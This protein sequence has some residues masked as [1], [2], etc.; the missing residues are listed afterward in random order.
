MGAKTGI[1]W[2][3][4]TWN[5][6]T[7]CEHV[8]PGCDNC[9]AEKI[10]ERFAG[11]KPY[12]NG[13]AP[14]VHRDRMDL[15]TRWRGKPR[16]VFVNSMSDLHHREFSWEDIAEVY[17]R[18][19]AE[20]EHDYLVLTKRPQRMAEFLVGPET[21]R[22]AYAAGV[23]AWAE[24]TDRPLDGWLGA[25][26]LRGLPDHI[27]IGTSIEDNQWAFRADW[28]RTIPAVVRAISA[29]PLIGPL[30]QLDLAG[31]HWVIVGGESGNRSNKFRPMPHEWARELLDR[32]RP[33]TSC[34]GT[35]WIEDECYQGP[36]ALTPREWNAIA[37]TYERSPGDGLIA[38]GCNIPVDETDVLPRRDPIAFFFKQSAGRTSGEH[39]F[40]DDERIE[41]YPLPHPADPARRGAHVGVY[42]MPEANA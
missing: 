24:F 18:M 21:A 1:S 38:C 16:R 36:D 4:A 3:E 12:P 28:L 42:T 11:T 23:P 17:D 22:A 20:P 35:R 32:C 39:P 13:F 34:G 37:A 40:L 27:W 5:P 15:P 7:G 25:R 8:S 31:I 30:D 19:V 6:M 29:E 2:T 41:E 14:T 33:C 9:Y 26:G 10:A